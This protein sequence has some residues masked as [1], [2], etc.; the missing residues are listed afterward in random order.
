MGRGPLY[1]LPRRPIKKN[2]NTTG[3]DHIA[4]TRPSPSPNHVGALAGTETLPPAA[5]LST[6][7]APH[8]TAHAQS[9]L[10]PPPPAAPESILH[11]TA[12][13]VSPARLAAP[14]LSTP[15][16]EARSNLGCYPITHRANP[17]ICFFLLRFLCIREKVSS[18]ANGADPEPRQ[19]AAQS[20]RPQ[21][22]LIS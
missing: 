11:A 7:T 16:P 18:G 10:P 6:R 15:P 22:S 20:R 4:H 5:F 9:S 17:Y 3:S 13:G 8:R 1:T 2:N 19:L 14:P 12:P 21:V